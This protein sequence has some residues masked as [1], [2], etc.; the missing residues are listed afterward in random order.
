MIVLGDLINILA[1]MNLLEHNMIYLRGRVY[2]G[3]WACVNVFLLYEVML[4][5]DC[6]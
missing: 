1:G 2:C 4:W 5:F 6:I 3:K